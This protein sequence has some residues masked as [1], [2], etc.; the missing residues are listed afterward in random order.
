MMR[1]VADTLMIDRRARG[2]GWAQ[3]LERVQ[4]AVSSAIA[5]EGAAP[6]SYGGEK[7]D[8]DQPPLDSLIQDVWASV[9]A[10]E[11][12]AELTEGEAN[13]VLFTASINGC[14]D[15]IFESLTAVLSLNAS[16]DFGFLAA[17]APW[18]R[19]SLSFRS[20]PL[21]CLPRMRPYLTVLDRAALYW[22][23]DGLQRVV[24]VHQRLPRRV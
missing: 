23:L 4:H 16:G 7:S 3:S 19:P 8:I 12:L 10:S 11:C 14:R 15:R 2:H 9:T 13:S 21:D 1:W 20:V 17:G 18:Q 5:D 22:L 24:P 6:P